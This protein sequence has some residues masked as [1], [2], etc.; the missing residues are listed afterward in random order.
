MLIARRRMRIG[1]VGLAAMAGCALWIAAVPPHPQLRPGV[2]ELTA[3]DVGQGD[4]LLLVSPEGRTLLLDAGGV[5]YWMHSGF[6]IG[7]EV[8][9]PYL[10]SR[11]ISRLDAVAVSHAHA[12]H[13]GGMSAILANFRPGEMWLG[14]ELLSPEL[15]KLIQ[16]AR[17]AHIAV[18][19]H[20]AGEMFAFGSAQIRVLAP[21]L[22]SKLWRRNDDSLAMKVSFGRTAMLLEGDAERPVERRIAGEQPQADLL[23]VAH[24]G[25]ATSTAPELLAAVHPKYAV[26]SV[27]ARNNYGHPRGEVLERLESAR[28][29]TYRTDLNGAVTFYLDGE[30]VSPQLA[31]QH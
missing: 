1:A 29:V 13:M 8:V 25:S 21:D 2:L 3:I 15:Q 23:K 18:A 17:Q 14:V 19:S 4:A 27:G 20:H 11:G 26:I 28:V 31:T 24:H 16:Q 10:W 7:E 6:D 9:S 12:D 30:R 22:G 5:P